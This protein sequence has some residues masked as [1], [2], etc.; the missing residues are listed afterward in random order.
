MSAVAL[1][2]PSFG[3]RVA[4]LLEQVDYRRADTEEERESIFRLRYDAY[5][6][7]GAI[8]SSFSKRMSD[9]YDDKKNAWIFGIYI[10]GELASSIRLNVTL[11]ECKELPALQVFGDILEP[12]IAAG[13][14]MIDPTRFVTDRVSSRLRPELPYAAVRLA[15]MACEY[16]S[17]DM[18]LATVRTEH[19]AFYR[20]IL[21]H[22]PLSM[23]RTYPSLTKPIVCMSLDYPEARE[24]VHRRYPFFRS[25]FFERRMLF[26][27][28]SQSAQRSAA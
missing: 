10:D 17:I 9:P 15:W 12:E 11:P 13:K 19:Q 4:S 28:P 26:E 24:Q 14:M 2:A 25:T 20:R 23:P 7:E 8:T 27:R 1:A 18:L 6:R 21:G 3:D 22:R 16:F 5:L